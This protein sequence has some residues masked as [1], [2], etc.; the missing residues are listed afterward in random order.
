MTR[1][2]QRHRADFA[3]HLGFDDLARH[4]VSPGR[5]VR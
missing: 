3:R 2:R 4:L 5:R 1:Q